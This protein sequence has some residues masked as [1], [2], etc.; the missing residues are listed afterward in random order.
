MLGSRF[1]RV[2][3]HL[4]VHL[5]V[6]QH[7]IDDV[8]HAVLDEDVRLNDLGGGIAGRDKLPARV[9]SEMEILAAGGY[10]G[11]VG[12]AWTVDGCSVDDVVPQDIPE[13]SGIARD[14]LGRGLVGGDQEGETA[15]SVKDLGDRCFFVS[16]VPSIPDR[17]VGVPGETCEP[18]QVTVGF[19]CAIDVSRVLEN[20]INDVDVKVLV[21]GLL[22]NLW[23][24]VGSG[25]YNDVEQRKVRKF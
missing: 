19:E 9:G 24:I 20:L 15:N 17:N 6:H 11:S 18:R 4:F 25:L 2:V 3:R 16:M 21:A 7:P 10:V 5:W 12:K 1:V 14:P 23:A 8:E 13:T 22:Q